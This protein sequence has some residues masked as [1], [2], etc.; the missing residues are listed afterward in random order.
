MNNNSIQIDSYLQNEMS[1]EEKA[2][3][4]AALLTDPELLHEME[5]QRSITQAAYNAGL[6][7][8][9][10]KAIRKRIMTTRLIRWGVIVL[11]GAG[12]VSLYTFRQ[13]IFHSTTAGNENIAQQNT[14]APFINPP[15]KSIDV[16][17]DEYDVDADTGDTIFAPSGS[18]ILFPP[19]A[20]ADEAG[21]IVKGKVNIRFRE[22][23]Q[24][25]DFFV[26]GITMAYDSAGTKYNFESS[27][28]CEINAYQNSKALFVN[29]AA[30]PE[31]FLSATNKSPLHNLYY[32]DTVK[33]SWTFIGKDTITEIKNLARATP[34]PATSIPATAGDY[35]E[36][37]MSIPA[38]PLKPMKASDD[39]QSFSIEI[40]PGSF[41]ELLAYDKLKF[42][43]ID[44][45]TY[46]RSD[47]DEH[48]DNVVLT[49][50]A[51][52]AIY[53]VTFSNARRKV[54]YK[55][56]P[57]LEG[58]DYAA[59]LKVFN[60]KNKAYEQAMKNRLAREKGESDSVSTLIANH[61]KK[62]LALKKENDRINAV[63]IA[64][65]KNMRQ[66]Q[67]KLNQKMESLST[68]EKVWFLN[69]EVNKSKFQK[70]LE[71]STEILRSFSINKFGAWNCDHPQYP[72]MEV[73]LIANYTDISNK[74]LLL[75]SIAVVYK[76]VNGI[77]QY[78]PLMQIR[79]MPTGDNMV[80][81]I[82]DSAFF[83][84]TYSDFKNAGLKAD[85]KAYTFKMRQAKTQVS[86]YEEI[87]ALVEKL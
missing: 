65:N 17:F 76:N 6:K 31:I 49:H 34:S 44:E 73:P 40:E 81:G 41:E 84:F 14:T 36:Q 27:G 71:Y 35:P 64:R 3:F 12:V 20:F 15:L 33:R 69:I 2:A 54:S 32:L 21:N 55:V 78:D 38:K 59:A 56:R 62:M 9:F 48:W 70:D 60:E 47:A 29:P 37:D 66:L 80:W 72:N 52:E 39:R 4:E 10:A 61:D 45:S 83:Y 30:K 77:R 87:K 46:K 26:S 50:T 58:E 13:S 1:A 57:V 74:P 43:V 82:R 24:P 5:V 79:F 42:E 16:P 86:S 85:S 53:T 75:S 22:F 23:T 7:L 8:S 18:V 68:V 11:A 63:I 67:L 51:A 28:M 19:A 25:V